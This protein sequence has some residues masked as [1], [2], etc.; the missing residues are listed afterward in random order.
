MDEPRQLTA[1]QV[2]Y[3]SFEGG[4]GKGAA[5]LGALAAL[6]HPEIG[7]LVYDDET[8]DY[9]LDRRTE[10][11]E[12]G[13]DGV[14]GASAGAITAALLASGWGIRA[15]YRDVI[16]DRESL[17]GF[18]DPAR[19]DR[20]QVPVALPPRLSESRTERFVRSSCLVERDDSLARLDD[21]GRLGRAYRLLSDSLWSAR[22]GA[23]TLFRLVTGDEPPPLSSDPAARQLLRNPEVHLRDL[24][25][26]YGLFAGCTARAFLDRTVSTGRFVA[27]AAADLGRAS[28]V[29]TDEGSPRNLT[30]AEHRR[31]TGVELVVTGT[32]LR[33]GRAAY[34]SARHGPVDMAVADAVRIS[35]GLPLVF[36]PVRIGSTADEAGWEP[37][38]EGLWVDG[39][40]LNN[41]PIHAFDVDGETNP[42]VLGL[43]LESDPAH[44]PEN[45]LEYL[46]A[47]VST[48]LNAAETREIRSAAEEARSVVLP[49][50]PGTLST[51][52]FTPDEAAVR[53]A[54]TE[55][56]G[57][58]LDYFGVEARPERV[59]EDVLE[60]AAPESG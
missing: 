51:L 60:L 35:M 42:N 5:Y 27:A 22:R 19:T 50:P 12:R 49:V 6:A 25:V 23:S 46:W 53:T 7:L 13:V 55:A 14:A 43:R 54:G 48:Y 57:A 40:V 26:D 4:G 3:I 38:Y 9:H 8:D 2:Q 11:A 33:T 21:R 29:G 16:A 30:F 31:L 17:A 24:V 41:N 32:N 28:P 1:E 59:L 34:L 44:V 39:G 18:F 58:V 52:A 56:A 45:L 20:R 10:G 36:K 37:G 47:L 15:L